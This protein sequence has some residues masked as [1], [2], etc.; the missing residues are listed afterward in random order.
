MTRAL[1]RGTERT[2]ARWPGPAPDPATCRSGPTRWSADGRT[3]AVVLVG[4]D[5]GNYRQPHEQDVFRQ[6]LLDA[7]TEASIDGILVVSSDTKM[8]SFNRR[9]VE[10]WGVPQDI[11]DSRSDELALAWVLQTLPTPTPSWPGW[12]TCTSTP[13]RRAGT[14]SR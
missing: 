10:M 14:S 12:P 8:L 13:T 1:L 2:S 3:D 4:V 5:L 11:V 6:V 7:Q 9:F